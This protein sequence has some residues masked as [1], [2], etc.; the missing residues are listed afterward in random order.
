MKA[1]FSKAKREDLFREIVGIFRQWP[2]LDR[3]VFFQ[4]HY[5]GKSVETISR[6]LNMDVEEVSIILKQCDRQ[7]NA[8]LRNFRQDT[9]DKPLPIPAKTARSEARGQDLKEV[10]ALAPKVTHALHS[11]QRPV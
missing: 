5:H 8:S 6:S 10:H 7:L 1:V 9:R 4:A 11:P 2:E 3:T